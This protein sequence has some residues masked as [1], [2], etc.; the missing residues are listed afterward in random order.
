MHNDAELPSKAA[1]DLLVVILIR[2]LSGNPTPITLHRTLTRSFATFEWPRV[3][4][5]QVGARK[6]NLLIARL[7]QASVGRV[8]FRELVD[9]VR[10]PTFGAPECHVMINGRM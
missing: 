1:I 2:A 8:V 5:E 6:L 3:L 10:A 7:R 4:A 9:T